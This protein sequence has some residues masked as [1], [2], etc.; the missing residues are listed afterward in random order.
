M[1]SW[2]KFTCHYGN[3]TVHPATVAFGMICCGAELKTEACYPVTIVTSAVDIV[4]G[5]LHAPHLA[6][7]FNIPP[8]HRL[9]ACIR[10]ERQSL[11]FA[12]V[13][14]DQFISSV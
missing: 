7:L 12:L 4:Q 6:G 3:G 13:R 11:Q 14:F 9:P 10:R 5:S 8:L 2:A 1:E